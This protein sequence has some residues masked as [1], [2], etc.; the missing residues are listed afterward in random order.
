[1]QFIAESVRLEY[2]I[3]FIRNEIVLELI[4]TRTKVEGAEGS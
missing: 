4:R 2:F 1:M 3:G